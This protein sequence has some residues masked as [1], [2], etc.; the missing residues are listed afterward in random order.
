MHILIV[1]DE[2][3]V[4]AGLERA[5]RGEHQ[6][7][8]A[9][10]YAEAINHLSKQVVDLA[11]VDLQLS[12]GE[13][14]PSGLR[15]I[16]TMRAENSAMTIIVMTGLDDTDLIARC[17]DLGATDYLFKPLLEKQVRLA[18]SKSKILHR[19]LRQNQSL[20]V[21]KSESDFI[22]GVQSQARCMLDLLKKLSK[23]RGRPE[24]VLIRGE[25]GAGKDVLANFLHKQEEDL[26]RPFIAVNCAAISQ[27]LA[28]SQLF[29][30]R[31]GAFS[32]AT[33]NRI[34]FIEAANGGDLFLDE[35]ATLNLEI[36]AKLLRALENREITPVGQTSSKKI[37]FRLIAATNENLDQ[38]VKD[39][40]F[41]E[42][43]LARLREV[44]V[45]IPP[46]RERIED[47]PA[48]IEYFLRDRGHSSKTISPEAMN[49]CMLYRWPENIR[50]LRHVINSAALFSETDT[51]TRRDIEAQIA[52]PEL[53][54][55]SEQGPGL[56]TEPS[57][58]EGAFLKMAAEYE[59][60]LVRA[61]IE[62]TGNDS[63]AARFLGIPRSTLRSKKNQWGWV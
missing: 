52:V 23:L 40:L 6:V 34:G 56:K 11:F 13:S 57:L 38:M 7:L 16:E 3:L 15:L 55:E 50:E 43:L 26:D 32:G 28:E 33:E 18:V 49:F 2:K 10:N 36:Q 63:A 22:N 54:S 48:L 59:Q 4:R 60:G 19:L 12:N 9:Q 29:G 8:V 27:T 31:K 30:H 5:L 61:A 25:T 44:S 62:K 39:K 24:S 35:I 17:F 41:R 45:V 14:D 1:D 21:Q 37:S 51:I 47:I 53:T 58:V 20:Q 46:L 42:D